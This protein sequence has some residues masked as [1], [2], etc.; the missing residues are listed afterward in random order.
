MAR[1]SGPKR[2]SNLYG[3]VAAPL[4]ARL[5]WGCLDETAC[6]EQQP[7][8]GRGDRRLSR[9]AA[10][11][12]ERPPLRRRGGVRRNQRER[13]RRG[14]VRHPVDQL[15]GQRQSDGAADLH[16][17]AAARVGQADHGG[18]ALF[19][20]CPA[21]PQAGPAHADL[22]QAGRQPDHHRR[23]QPG[24]VDRPACRADP[25]LL[26]HPDRQSVRLAGDRRRHPRAA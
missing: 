1:F 20:L 9:D 18:D 5:R 12:C 2:R 3:L 17:R 13:P 16:R 8:A 21:G 22:G 10:D 14:R 19:R 15:P 26:R 6:R 11:R 24:A 7:A 4:K 23:R 25:G